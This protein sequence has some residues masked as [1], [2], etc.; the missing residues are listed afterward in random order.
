MSTK[1][2]DGGGSVLAIGATPTTIGE[3]QS[4][5]QSGCKWDTEEASNLASTAKE[6]VATILDW[7]E[8]AVE[9]K[10]VS[11]DAGQALVV[12]AFGTGALTSFTLTLPK[13]ATQTVNGDK[14]VF[15]AVVTEC[16][17]SLDV[18]KLI[19]LSFKLKVSGGVAYT[20]GS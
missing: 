5:K 13:E 4:V 7:G 20:E 12:A 15:S 10:R 6:F 1:A 18:N 16:D 19:P 3:I 11:T 9:A 8:F 14:Y 2:T 17:F